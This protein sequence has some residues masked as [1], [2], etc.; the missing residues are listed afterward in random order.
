MAIYHFQMKTVSRSQGRS[1][2]AAAAYR[3]GERIEDERTGL[4]HDYSK[5]SGVLMAEV[6]LPDGGTVEREAL[7]NAAEGAEKRCNSVVAREFVVA[8]PHELN[9]EQQQDL[10]RGYAQGLSERTG[11][12]VDVAVHAPGKE[13]DIRNVHAHLLCTTRK[14][15]TDP[16]GCPV[17]RQKTRD[18]DQ[19]ATGSELLRLERSE[20][21]QCVNQSLEQAHCVERVDCRSHAEKHS[22][23]TPQIHLG[24]N[25]MGMERRGIETQR[26]D[27]YR[28]IAAHNAKV[29]EFQTVQYERIE[30]EFEQTRWRHELVQM[31]QM[32]LEQLVKKREKYRPEP[33]DAL[34]Q[35]DSAV[36]KA[37]QEA[38]R[39][40]NE[41][42][43]LQ[44]R[45]DD[46][47]YNQRHNAAELSRYR[48]EHPWKARLHDLRVMP[49]QEM[50]SRQEQDA[51][52]KAEKTKL[53]KEMLQSQ[54]VTMIGVNALSNARSNAMPGALRE[55]ERQQS[56][57]KD[58]ESIYHPRKEQEIVREEAL[59]RQKELERP[60]E[61][62]QRDKDRGQGWSR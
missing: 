17:M 40:K 10:V 9:R 58:V 32:P 6:V 35:K 5:R 33:V 27:E 2:T 13:G 45:L 30:E 3:S 62:Q 4:V 38:E 43:Q 24:P 18:W 55:H 20:W 16:D 12:A 56:Y 36:E 47:V 1:A 29:V 46:N 23:L 34:V 61:R 26:G 44:E 50:S 53:D 19:R 48:E 11:W 41:H 60:Q 22:G 52:L 51:A 15:D 8:L 39:L 42:A 28:E 59:R 49:D 25:V 31:R 54:R 57:F 14:I 37:S 21:E 7:W